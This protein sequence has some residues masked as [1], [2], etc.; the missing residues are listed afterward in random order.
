MPKMRY[1]VK[2]EDFPYE[3]ITKLL[4]E[5]YKEHL[6][7]GRN[8]LAATQTVEDTKRRLDGRIVGLCYNEDNKLVG[9]IA[10]KIINK[11]DGEP[12]KWYEDDHYLYVEQMAVHPDYRKT[13]VLAMMSITA[14][15]DKSLREVD[16]W[17]SDT[18]SLATD[19]VESYVKMGFQIV[20]MVSWETTNYY[21][22]VFRRPL[23]GRKFD[24]K[25]VNRKFFFSKLICKLRYTENGKKRF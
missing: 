15:K 10:G 13:N 12:R 6:E 17:M 3:E 18:S 21:S 9:T 2:T 22:Y 23:K 16:S 24:Q 5:S 14:M 1:E 4:H 11:H 7:A 25:Y 20:D 8:Y 19:L